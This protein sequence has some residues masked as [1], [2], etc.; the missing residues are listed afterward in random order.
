MKA[1]HLLNRAGLAA[2]RRRST[3][4]SSSAPQKAVELADGFPRRPA[5]EQSQNDMPD[6]S[7]IE[8]MP[9]SFRAIQV[10]LASKTPEERKALQQQFM[11]ANREALDATQHWWL[12]RMA[13]G[14]YPLQEKLT[15]FWHG[16]FT[17]SAKD[18]RSALLMW[19]QNEL[20][21]R[22][23]AG[24][25]EP[26]VRA[27]SRD[28]AMLDY[29]NNTQ[30]RK[31]HPNENYAR[32]LMELFTLGIGNYTE[33]DIK[34]A[35]RAFTG[36]AHD[37]DRFRLPRRTSTMTASKHFFGRTGNFNGDDIIAMILLNPACPK[38]IAGELFKYFVYEESTRISGQTARRC[39][40]SP[41]TTNFAR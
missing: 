31:A 6:L 39:I 18:E 1:A 12:N 21:R 38:F 3:D 40:A 25:F 41:T 8:G 7:A 30:N 37:G 34:Q 35:A 4:S 23:A 36:W 24:N 33:D 19:Q 13:V 32:E 11:A 28:P 14:P 5:E 10:Q 2:R 22:Y 29:L 26:F 17:T 9:N 15:F 16:H 20:L 27:I